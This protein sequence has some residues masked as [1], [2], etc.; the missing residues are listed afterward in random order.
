MLL[1]DEILLYAIAH[2]FTTHSILH[3]ETIYLG[4]K[5]M[6]S[7]PFSPQTDSLL[8]ADLLPKQNSEMSVLSEDLSEEERFWFTILLLRT[9]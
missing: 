2:N 4:I 6:Q 8:S 5:S 9:C 3:R 1:N 7:L